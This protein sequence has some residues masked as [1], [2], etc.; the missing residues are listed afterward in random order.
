MPTR[1]TLEQATQAARCALENE[2]LTTR[3]GDTVVI[4]PGTSIDAVLAVVL[5]AVADT[6][7]RPQPVINIQVLHEVLDAGMAGYAGTALHRLTTAI[8]A[9][10]VTVIE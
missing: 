4:A 10:G 5:D 2:A 1:T 3:T 9:A 8:R 6:L 7:P